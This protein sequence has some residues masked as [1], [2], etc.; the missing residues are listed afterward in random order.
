MNLIN[1]QN[2]YVS[3]EKY[4]L[5]LIDSSSSKLWNSFFSLGHH[6]KH[7]FQPEIILSVLVEDK[8]PVQICNSNYEINIILTL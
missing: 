1:L 3:V 4:L 7:E 8:P 2:L 5:F 6:S